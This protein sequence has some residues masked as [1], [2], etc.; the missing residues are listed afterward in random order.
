MYVNRMVNTVID[1]AEA[2]L[3][4]NFVFKIELVAKDWQAILV[5]H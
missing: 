2:I 4:W 5:Y 3:G 1:M